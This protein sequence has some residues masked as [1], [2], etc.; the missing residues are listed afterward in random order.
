MSACLQG[1]R[2]T[3]DPQAEGAEAQALRGAAQKA[4]A[5]AITDRAERLSRAGDRDIVLSLDGHLRWQ[6][7]PIA[8]LVAGDDALKP[9]FVILADEQ[10]SGPPRELVEARL[11][12]WLTH[13]YRDAC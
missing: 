11:T 10:L 3:P 1:F 6:G 4:L 9:R 2:F 7:E 5:T 8:R 12:A 13:T